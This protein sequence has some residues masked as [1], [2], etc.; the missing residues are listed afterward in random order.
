PGAR[1]F[2]ICGRVDWDHRGAF[3]PQRAIDAGR[4]S[5]AHSTS[6]CISGNRMSGTGM[7]S[8]R[9]ETT[10]VD[11]GGGPES[12]AVSR[13]FATLPALRKK[14][15]RFWF[16]PATTDTISYPSSTRSSIIRSVGCHWSPGGRGGDTAVSEWASAAEERVIA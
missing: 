2:R 11:A 12:A 14:K 5:S 10:L 7:E 9:P 16:D 3:S 4:T 13:H 8:L 6:I 1:S 15:V